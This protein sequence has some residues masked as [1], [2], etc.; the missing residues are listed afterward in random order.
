MAAATLPPVI[1]DLGR[2]NRK[3]IRDLKKHEGLL[4]QDVAKTVAEVRASSAELANK[5]L[6][7]LVFIYQKR[8]RRGKMSGQMMGMLPRGM[9]PCCGKM[10]PGC[11]CS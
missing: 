4:M 8:S 5:E 1:I 10:I 6:V 7:P 11:C 2:Q 9:M 3:R